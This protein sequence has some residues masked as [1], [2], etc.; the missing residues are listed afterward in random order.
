MSGTVHR[1]DFTFRRFDE[2]L[3]ELE[4]LLKSWFD[5]KVHGRLVPDAKDEEVALLG[6][7]VTSCPGGTKMKADA[8]HREASTKYCGLDSTSK[9]LGN[10]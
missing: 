9:G 2:D 6:G 7:T 8:K 5:L 4:E 10:P 3:D 1:D